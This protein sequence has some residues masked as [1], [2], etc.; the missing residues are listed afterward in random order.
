MHS[1]ERALP[2]T[3]HDCVNLNK[4]SV[5]LERLPTTHFLRLHLQ[6]ERKISSPPAALAAQC[7]TTEL[8]LWTIPASIG[9]GLV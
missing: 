6:R 3:A 7:L 9:R 8:A 5:R 4:P 2:R 1:D